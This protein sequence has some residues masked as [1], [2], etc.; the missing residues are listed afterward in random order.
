MVHK[1]GFPEQGDIV[2][3]TVKDI[4]PYSANCVLDEYPG[5]EGMIHISELDFKRTEKVTDVVNVG[6][7][8]DV[9]VKKIDNEGKIGLSRK[10]YLRR[11]Q[12][13][14]EEIKAE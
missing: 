11:Q 5:K 14:P 13:K 3:V 2:I 6:D 10:D 12:D 7:S 8:V 9:L 4:T 1:K